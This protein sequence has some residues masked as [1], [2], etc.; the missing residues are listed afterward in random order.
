MTGT[1]T[2][3]GLFRSGLTALKRE[4]CVVLVVGQVQCDLLDAL[5]ARLLGDACEGGDRARLFGLLD[6]TVGRARTRLSMAAGTGD[7]RVVATAGGRAAAVGGGATDAA[8]DGV[9]VGDAPGDD[10]SPD[11]PALD[12]VTTE[13][14][15]RDDAVPDDVALDDVVAGDVTALDRT[16]TD[17]ASGGALDDAGGGAVERVPDERQFVEAFPAVVED[18]AAQNRPLDR[19][20]LRVC[21]DSVRPLVAAD[22]VDHRAFVE[23]V[24]GEM[25][26]RRG[27]AHF[28][29]PGPADGE[30]ARSL[31]PLFDVVVSLRTRDGPE[32]RWHLR[33][34]DYRTD[35]VRY[36]H[37]P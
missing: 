6:R 37:V 16:A 24:R 8:T 22:S 29:L 28:V 26:R 34:V 15:T 4:G 20:E 12:G 10:G 9:A 13:D 32:Q 21:V 17:D 25:K 31:A 33:N 27:I 11:A 19:A 3:T 30:V 36:P 5:S 18:F 35:W 7:C 1:P 14:A 2:T 23:T